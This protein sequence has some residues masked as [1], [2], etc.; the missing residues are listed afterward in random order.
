MRVIE[1]GDSLRLAQ[2]EAHYILG[3]VIRIGTKLGSNDFD[4]H[5]PVDACILSK[6]DLTHS[7]ATNEAEQ[8]IASIL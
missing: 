2:E 1:S 8:A 7:S 5:L 6:V 4:S 3:S